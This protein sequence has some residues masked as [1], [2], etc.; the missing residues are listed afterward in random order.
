[1]IFQQ[2]IAHLIGSI[3]LS[4]ALLL[5]VAVQLA[6]TFDSHEHKPCKEV[7]VHF[8]EKQLD[9][10]ICSF[11]LSSFT[12]ELLTSE[13]VSEAIKTLTITTFYTY[14]KE[15]ETLYSYSLRGPP[16]TLS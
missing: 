10:S 16:A 11:H 12:Y 2:K 5:P 13:T 15:T 7:S 4:I 1:M 8:H 14:W 9:C 3:L 6:H